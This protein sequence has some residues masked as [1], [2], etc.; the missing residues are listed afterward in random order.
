MVGDVLEQAYQRGKQYEADYHGCA[1]CVLA[2]L[3]DAFGQRARGSGGEAGIQQVLRIRGS[4]DPCLRRGDV[5]FRFYNT[6][7]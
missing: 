6:L 7:Y 2:A 3:Q 5:L 1:Q 4:L